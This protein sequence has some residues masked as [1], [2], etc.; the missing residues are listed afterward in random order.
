MKILAGLIA[1]WLAAAAVVVIFLLGD[2]N[3]CTPTGSAPSG[4][5]G[6]PAGTGHTWPV[7]PAVFTV[8]DV[9]GARGGTHL[10]VDMAAP[11]GTPIYAAMDG[12]VA[13][14]GAASGFGDWIVLDHNIDGQ[15]WSTVYGHMYE[16]D[17]LVAVGDQVKA[18]QQIS[19]VGTNG[20]STGPHLHFEVRQPPGRLA[21]GQAIDPMPWLQDGGTATPS[22]DPHAANQ[23]AATTP[24]PTSAP[25]APAPTAA[26]AASGC[27]TSGSGG[28]VDNL[29]PGSV[30]PQF[31]QWYR[32]AGTTCPEISSALLAAQGDHESGFRTD[33]VSPDGALG[34]AQFMPG[35]ATATAPDGQPY[36]I[37]AD[38]NGRADP[39]D[40]ADGIIGQ[41]RYMCAIAHTI[42][43]WEVD[44][45]V[46]GD[47]TALTIA[48]YNAGE[49]AV[50]DSGGMPNQ[51]PRH[52][53]ET[54]PYVAAILADIPTYAQQLS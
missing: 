34:I 27:G 4:G 50:L 1:L 33:A 28:G 40:P 9:F 44:G 18:G 21:G 52:F 26:A 37:D 16:K 53:T 14:S 46:T 17:L 13:A 24:A 45:K 20:E 41:A 25:A 32:K 31:E 29:K 5:S 49:G 42:E 39:M 48:A 22:P 54:R 35:T 36:V 6:V 43:G 51:I 19:R 3:T 11:E 2:D 7:D 10:G 38:G 47:V 15:I 8:S 23:A 12:T 30:P